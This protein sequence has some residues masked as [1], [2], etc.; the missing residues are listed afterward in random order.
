M[1]DIERFIDDCGRAT[2]SDRA[3]KA[4]REVLARAVSE[5]NEIIAALGEPTEAGATALH[6][7]SELTIINVVWAP[8]MTIVPHDHRMW[9]AIG[10]YGGREDNIYWRRRE[11][12]RI[13]AAG[14]SSLSVRD[15]VPLGKD[16]IH[17]LLNPIPRLTAAIH[18]YGGDFFGQARSEWDPEMLTERPYN[19]ERNMSLFKDPSVRARVSG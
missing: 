3:P 18:I 16:I 8:M 2:A 6:H 14:A 17:S 11:D 19:K 9:A 12:G 4:V 13:E 15:A 1:L 7:S 10:I 5:P